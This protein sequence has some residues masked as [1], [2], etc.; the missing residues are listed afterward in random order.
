MHIYPFFSTTSIFLFHFLHITS[1]TQACRMIYISPLPSISGF[2]PPLILVHLEQY[3]YNT[4]PFPLPYNHVNINN[5]S[6][7][8]SS[9]P[10]VPFPNMFVSSQ[11]RKQERR[12]TP[13]SCPH[14]RNM[15]SH[16]II[17]VVDLFIRHIS[18]RHSPPVHHIIHIPHR[19]T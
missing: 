6:I 5:E 7:R 14:H 1:Y 11:Q 19:G 10:F 4:P 2:A 15:H 9:P 3:I 17:P 8:L 16:E 12:S 18:S 13:L